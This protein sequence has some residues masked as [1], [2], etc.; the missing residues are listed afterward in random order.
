MIEFTA[1]QFFVS[2]YF[3]HFSSSSI[4]LDFQIFMSQLYQ[5]FIIVEEVNLGDKQFISID[6]A[7]NSGDP[8]CWIEDVTVIEVIFSSLACLTIA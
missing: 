8:L 3:E 2:C 7:L 1:N 4:Y 5:S 6:D